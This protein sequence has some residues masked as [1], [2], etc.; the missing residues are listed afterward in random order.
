MSRTLGIV[1]VLEVLVSL[2]RCGRGV[3]VQWTAFLD[4]SCVCSGLLYVPPSSS[5]HI[6]IP[7]PTIRPHD[8][9]LPHHTTTAYQAL[10]RPT[11]EAS[12]ASMQTSTTPAPHR[13][14]GIK[15]DKPLDTRT[16]HATRQNLTL[17]RKRRTPTM[18]ARS[19]PDRTLNSIVRLQRW[20]GHMIGC[21]ERMNGRVRPPASRPREIW[22][23]LT[24][25]RGWATDEV[26][27]DVRVLRRNSGIV[28]CGRERLGSWVG[29]LVV[30]AG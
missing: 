11:P 21:C 26:G 8:H 19:M 3:I 2:N 24:W 12:P 5:H 9:F 18:N 25:R 1:I 4:G 23:V 6:F 29:D 16:S 10:P 14:I 20:R 28:L 7:H 13:T 30:C 17:R 22:V 15:A 27:I